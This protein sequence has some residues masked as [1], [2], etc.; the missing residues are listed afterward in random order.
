MVSNPKIVGID[1]SDLY[2]RQRTKCLAQ[3]ISKRLA[4]VRW[5]NERVDRAPHGIREEK[6]PGRNRHYAPRKV[7]AHMATLANRINVAD[8]DCL[9]SSFKCNG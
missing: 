1:R 3:I 5:Q 7:A 2:F 4:W 8:V 6:R 9:V